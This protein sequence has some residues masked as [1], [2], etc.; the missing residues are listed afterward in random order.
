MAE[1]VFLCASSDGAMDAPGR[2]SMRTRSR[3]EGKMTARGLARADGASGSMGPQADATAV[4]PADMTR[5]DGSGDAIDPRRRIRWHS[6]IPTDAPT[7][8]GKRRPVRRSREDIVVDRV[9]EGAPMVPSP[10]GSIDPV[11][12]QPAGSVVPVRR[13]LT[14]DAVGNQTGAHCSTATMGMV[15]SSQE[16]PR[17][18]VGDG[19]LKEPR[20]GSYTSE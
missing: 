4:R 6:D 18:R 1:A 9:G 14:D 11:M 16:P 12:A 5:R 2:T 15:G 17:Q 10:S 19:C 13:R 20:A 7:L 3:G 8:T